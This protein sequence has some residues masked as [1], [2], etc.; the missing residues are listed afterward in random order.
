MNNR[1]PKKNGV[2]HTTMNVLSF[3]ADSTPAVTTAVTGYL[4][5]GLKEGVRA[6][7]HQAT[8]TGA[9]LMDV[10]NHMVKDTTMK[11]VDVVGLTAVSRE[12]VKFYT[13]L[14]QV[15]DCLTGGQITLMMM[16]SIA[17]EAGMGYGLYNMINNHGED[18][19]KHMVANTAAF[20][21]SA[22]ALTLGRY[23]TTMWANRNIKNGNVPNKGYQKVSLDLDDLEEQVAETTRP[24][25]SNM[26]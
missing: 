14:Y 9:I 1:P 25:F 12:T 7:A 13:N 6:I 24:R 22:E 18:N 19:E 4:G 23:L 3:L 11:V 5:Y 8:D 21:S 15:S 17:A 26:G 16:Y 10:A 2:G 20:A